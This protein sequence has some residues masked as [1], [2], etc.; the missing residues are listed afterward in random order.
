MTDNL[1]AVMMRSVLRVIPVITALMLAGC[2]S[3]FE[4]WPA[5]EIAGPADS[6]PKFVMLQPNTQGEGIVNTATVRKLIE[7]KGRIEHAAA[8]ARTEFYL[9]SGDEGPNAY[10]AVV[11]GS[12]VIGINLSMIELFKTDWDAYAGILSHLYAHLK[13]NH[14]GTRKNQDIQQSATN[15]VS[16][17]LKSIGVPV[18]GRA[19]Q[20]AS[21][22]ATM[23]YPANEEIEAD[24]TA[25]Q[26][27]R[28]AGFNVKAALASWSRLRSVSSQRLV[29][30]LDTH[31]ATER[32]VAFLR[33]LA[34]QR[35]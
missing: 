15:T 18:Q 28:K 21:M 35:K 23:V 24:R 11:D 33:K 32:R 20:A 10:A 29:P 25:L 22:A 30:F 19:E 26:Y 14:R 12:P 31:P 7:I 9:S 2:A 16:A 13:L 8:Y 4:A 27:L 6:S 17:T 3:H 34:T 5:S 1:T